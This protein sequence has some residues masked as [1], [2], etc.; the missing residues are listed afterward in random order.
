MGKILLNITPGEPLSLVKKL[1]YFDNPIE[2][3]VLLVG[4]LHLGVHDSINYH[5]FNSVR[6][7]SCRI[8]VLGH[9][10]SV[11]ERWKIWSKQ[12]HIKYGVRAKERENST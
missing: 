12:F 1:P 2:L 6:I 11:K 3:D 10:Q 4:A 5:L 7:Y 9:I 8:Q